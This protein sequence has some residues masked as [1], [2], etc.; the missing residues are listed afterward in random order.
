MIRSVLKDPRCLQVQ[1]QGY[2]WQDKRTERG[3]LQETLRDYS[4]TVR[5]WLAIW[6]F[7]SYCEWTLYTSAPRALGVATLFSDCR[8]EKALEAERGGLAGKHSQPCTAWDEKICWD[9]LEEASSEIKASKA[10]GSILCTWAQS[11]YWG[12]RHWMLMAVTLLP[13]KG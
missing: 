11:R 13:L 9:V 1:V 12:P 5:I 6:G 2:Q 3:L 7:K 4:G 8:L 10:N